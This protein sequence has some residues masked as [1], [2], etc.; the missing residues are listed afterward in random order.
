MSKKKVESFPKT[1]YV[2]NEEDGDST[3]LLCFKNEADLS[4]Y[5]GQVVGIYALSKSGKLKTTVEI[6]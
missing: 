6:K 2:I 4:E 1:I 5:D 3:Y